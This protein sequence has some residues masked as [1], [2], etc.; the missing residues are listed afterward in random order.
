MLGTAL[1]DSLGLPMEGL[2][3][4][5]QKKLFPRLLRQGLVFGYGMVSDD[6]DHAF[7]VAQSLSA[8]ADDADRFQR[9]LAWCL[10]GWLL[11]LPT[12]IGFATLR[13]IVLLWLGVPPGRSAVFSAGNGPAMRA[14]VIG[15]FFGSQEQD[16]ER[17]VGLSSSLT[18]RDPKAQIGAL[19]VARM[20]ARLREEDPAA[21]PG[22]DWLRECLDDPRA[23]AE[24]EE[25][26]SKIRGAVSTE[27]SV[28]DLARSLGL[29]KGVS[30]YMYHT[31]PIALYAVWR[32]WAN[33]SA[34]LEA[35]VDA[36]GD[37]DTVG[38]IAGGLAGFLVGEE[39]LPDPWLRKLWDPPRGVATLRAAGCRLADPPGQRSG[40][41]RWPWPLLPIRHAIQLLV[42]LAHGVRRLAPPYG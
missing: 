40:P 8:Y 21:R 38:A 18:H 28:K 32:H 19:A 23:D 13:S 20:A 36:G 27:A 1:G 3:P 37:T 16:L 10:R 15:A 34:T 7:F 11:S 39:A 25:I 42:V 22:W 33:F 35:V 2:S 29:D 31:V 9:R 6:T 30:G 12:G 17:F 4:Q 41:V 14:P 24:W 26:I 5:R